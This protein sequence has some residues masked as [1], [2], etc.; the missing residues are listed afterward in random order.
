M[1]LDP[2]QPLVEGGRARWRAWPPPPCCA[3]R[4]VGA[5]TSR[6]PVS[7]GGQQRPSSRSTNVCTG[8][9]PEQVKQPPQPQVGQRR[10]AGRSDRAT[11]PSRPALR[12]HVGDLVASRNERRTVPDRAGRRADPDDQAVPARADRAEAARTRGVGPRAER[13]HLARRGHRP[14]FRPATESLGRQ[15][16]AARVGDVKHPA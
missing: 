8:D 13:Q 15:P 10:N 14:A 9:R 11:E 3:G 2:P 4:Q 7:V 6:S 16:A 5:S 1:W 12:G